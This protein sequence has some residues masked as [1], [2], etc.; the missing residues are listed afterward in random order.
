[1]SAI[2]SAVDRA[3]KAAASIHRIEQAIARNPDDGALRLNLASATK[4]AFQANAFLQKAAQYQHLEICNYR[5]M[6]E[7]HDSFAI[8]H[9]SKSVLE[10]QYL[11]SQIHDAVKNGTKKK[12]ILG[13]EAKSESTLEFGYSYSGSLGMVLLAQNDRNFFEGRL[14]KSIEA[15]FDIVSM[16]ALEDAKRTAHQFGKAVVKRLHDWSQAN[17]KGG[18]AADVRW[19]R[20]DGKELGQVVERSRMENMLSILSEASDEKHERLVVH[21]VLVGADLM[22]GT[23]HLVESNGES[24]KGMLNPD[25]SFGQLT[26]DQRYVAEINQLTIERYATDDVTKKYVLLSLRRPAEDLKEAINTET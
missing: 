22:N 14:D 19:T 10:Y 1:M 21:G 3:R 8:E 9:V 20:S 17:V 15:F 2:A 25:Q 13:D 4:M 12:A 26:L 5:L 16:T 6:P 7:H 11:F 24:F 23:F 18:F